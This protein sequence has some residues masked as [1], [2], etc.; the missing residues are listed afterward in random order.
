MYD[1]ANQDMH[2]DRTTPRGPIMIGDFDE[3]HRI[4]ELLAE[5]SRG[6]S[7]T[8]ISHALKIHRTTVA[9]YLD[10]M[11]MKGDVDLR[12]V[13][14]AKMYHLST[15]MPSSALA[16][17]THEPYLII[18]CRMIIS[19][20]GNGLAE[21]LGIRGDPVGKS[22]NDPL[23]TGILDTAMIARIK[24]AIQ[25]TPDTATLTL[26]HEGSNRWFEISVIPVVCPDG[27]PGSALVFYDQTPLKEAIHQAERCMAEAIAL[28]ADQTEFIF[29]S[30]TDGVIT[31]VNDAFYRRMERTREDLVGFPYE[32]VISH[33]DL[34]QLSHLRSRI[35]VAEPAFRIE[36][37]A[38][39]P[40]GMVAWESWLYRGIFTSDGELAGYHAIG[41][42]VSER[43]HLED[44]LRTYHANFEGIVKQRTREMRSA[45]QDLM[46]EIARREK[47]ERELLIIRFVFDQ[48][49]DSILLFDKVGA[50]YR[51]NE[52]ACRLL[53]YSPADITSITVFDVN[54]E[55]TPELWHE[56]WTRTDGRGDEEEA[57]RVISVHRRKDGEII[58][59]E[60]SRKF[61]S[62]GPI[63]LFCSIARQITQ[64]TIRNECP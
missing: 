54:P 23:V 13:S 1:N 58:P 63:S 61:I 57:S 50:L 24:Q 28:A 53:G 26:F 35:T 52:T 39:Q 38:I 18:T 56:M 42:D 4:R 20:A 46:S 44:Q 60:V 25:G 21:R 9:K 59:V 8:E 30:R 48:A 47:L 5:N 37:K 11:Q 51:A 62:A 12:V 64:D 16:I 33:E 17:W 15:R 43:K 40:D 31:Y 55:I 10:S 32:P 7:I 27:R 41:S 36:F 19:H 22:I 29:R 49:S 34:E 14:T 2:H 3:I 6:M 45:N